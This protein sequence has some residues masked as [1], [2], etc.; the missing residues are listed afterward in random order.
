[1]PDRIVRAGILTS[2]PVN[3]LSWAAEV[4]YR[5]LLSI[6]D[7]FG[8][9]DGRATLL[10]AHLYPLKIDRVSDA[11]VG[12]WLAECAT[13]G[14]VSVYQVSGQPFLEVAKFGQRV[15]ADKSKWPAPQTSADICQQPH[16]NAP[17]FV[18]V[19]GDVDVGVDEKGARKR[20]P[21]FDAA[22][23]ELPEWLD[24]ALWME[25][26][27]D[28]KK[29]GKAI[30]E[31]GAGKQIEKLNE[32]RLAGTLPKA[33]LDHAMASGNQG[34]FP[35]PQPRAATRLQVVQP[36]AEKLAEAAR[37]L[38]YGPSTQPEAMDA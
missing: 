27:A 31:I 35:P 25:W 37:L 29:R 12:K 7:D 38:G 14:L 22:A 1:M 11:D 24:R 15:R 30:T 8:R 10:R 33:V 6:V 4:L 36:P 13:A 26:T 18:S 3:T 2:D 5:R 16:A 32:Y 19:V 21:S 28:R 9:Y 20:A 17:V 23:I 34:L